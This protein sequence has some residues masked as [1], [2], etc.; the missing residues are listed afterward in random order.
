[1]STTYGWL[2]IAKVG[3]VAVLVAVASLSR[4]L[5]VPIANED[6]GAARRLRTV[7]IAEAAVA[8]V[9]LGVTSVLVQIT[10]ARTAVSQTSTPSVQDAVLTD[11]LFTL[12]VDM[13]PS[14]VGPN[15]IHLYATDARRAAVGRASS[16]RC[17][18]QCRR[19][20]SSRSTP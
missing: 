18:P 6:A 17:G 20:G 13:Q 7:V 19:R 10:P 12:T 2:I 5:V 1:M 4:R 3:L 11:K 14:T 9:V 16:G 8:V 15:D